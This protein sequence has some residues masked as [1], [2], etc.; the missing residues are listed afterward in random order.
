VPP[1]ENALAA[2]DHPDPGRDSRAGG[3]SLVHV[4]GGEGRQL[5]ERAVRIEEPVD[6]LPRGQLAPRAVFLERLL[7]AAA[8]DLLGAPA[9]LCDELLHPGAPLRE[10]VR[11]VDVRG[12]HRHTAEL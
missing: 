5:E 2:L 9:Q 12:E 4:P 8:C 11:F 1:D 6:P 7:A 10:R 3:L